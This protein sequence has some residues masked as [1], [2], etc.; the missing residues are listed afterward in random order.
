MQIIGLLGGIGAGKSSVAQMFAQLGATIIDADTLT[1]EALQEADVQSQITAL[2]GSHLLV[3]GKIDRQ[4][5]ARIVFANP[6]GNTGQPPAGQQCQELKKLEDLLHPRVRQKILH[7]LASLANTAT[8]AV[9]LD[10]PL[11]WERGLYQQCNILIF[12]DSPWSVRKDRVEHSRHWSEQDL[13][14]RQR[15]QADLAEKRAAAH[16]VI[17]NGKSVDETRKQVA[18][19][20]GALLV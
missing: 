11:L 19:I 13:A 4:A 14:A 9:I 1:H 17:D 5:L 3:N 18:A 15:L 10:V 20:W 6:A 16:Y 12:V 2:W 8:P 7:R